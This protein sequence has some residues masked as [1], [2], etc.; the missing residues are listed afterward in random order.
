MSLIVTDDGNII[1]LE[2]GRLS[3]ARHKKTSFIQVGFKEKITEDGM[4]VIQIDNAERSVVSKVLSEIT[5]S[6]LEVEDEIIVTKNKDYIISTGV[7][8]SEYTV[9]PVMKQADMPY[10]S[11]VDK[12]TL[13]RL[14]FGY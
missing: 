14:G 1:K 5:N 13:I 3:G 11:D 4:F 7:H 12:S 9:H 10:M 6:D 8:E 2:G